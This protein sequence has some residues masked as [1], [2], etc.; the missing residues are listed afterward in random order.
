MIVTH[1]SSVENKINEDDAEETTSPENNPEGTLTQ[2]QGTTI[3]VEQKSWKSTTTMGNV[4]INIDELSEKLKS[5]YPQKT[6]PGAAHE[7]QTPLIKPADAG[8]QPGQMFVQPQ[9]SSISQTPQIQ[10]AQGF[11]YPHFQGQVP[12]TGQAMPQLAQAGIPN[13]LPTTQSASHLQGVVGS[14]GFVQIQQPGH[15]HS[16]STVP[17]DTQV[18]PKSAAQM[19]P[20][21]SAVGQQVPNV[22]GHQAQYPVPS[23]QQNVLQESS[24]GDV[25][26]QTAA[27]SSAPGQNMPQDPSAKTGGLPPAAYNTLGH[28]GYGIHPHVSHLSQ[29]QQMQQMF[30]L[31]HMAP[32]S[33]HQPSYY[34][35]MTPYMQTMMHMSHMMHQ[36]QQHQQQHGQ[37]SLPMHLTFPYS[38]Y[39]GWGYPSTVSLPPQSSHPPESSSVSSGAS[40]PRS[41]TSSRRN[42]LQDMSVQSPYASI[43]N[44]STL[45][46]SMPRSDI[47]TLEQALA[48]TMSRQ[49]HPHPHNPSPVS[50]GTNIQEGATEAKVA[51]QPADV[52]DKLR[53]E[54]DKMLTDRGTLA[55]SSPPC[56]TETKS[57]PDLSAPKVKAIS[58]FKVETVKEDPL[59]QANDTEN[60]ATSP[61]GESSKTN[62]TEEKKIEK[63]GRFQVTKIAVKPADSTSSEGTSADATSSA[64]GIT[65]P[66]I[67][68]LSDTKQDAVDPTTNFQSQGEGA[69]DNTQSAGVSKCVIKINGDP[70]ALNSINANT[71]Y[72]PACNS[73][74]PVCMSNLTKR[75]RS[76]SVDHLYAAEKPGVLESSPSL[77][78]LTHVGGRLSKM[79]K[80]KCLM[81][82]PASCFSGKGMLGECPCCA[83]DGCLKTKPRL[84][85]R[86]TPTWPDHRRASQVS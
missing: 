82:S 70:I 48:K 7:S 1:Q 27:P 15:D 32:Y 51:D 77:S 24:T 25:P 72:F 64:S 38:Q 59:L 35:H 54:D 30:A 65:K 20:G 62:V 50:S 79:C 34:A 21:H 33:F 36:M 67:S 52:P 75:G 6:G 16:M 84:R 55:D 39:S 45:G 58:R 41:P 11:A 14:A 42:I 19:Q 74:L 37:H 85:K 17:M 23:Q 57:E 63:R 80:P 29:M 12:S 60:K 46:R 3:D 83:T 18:S 22:Q 73:S 78:R 56:P 9:S 13:Q 69:S 47:N 81:H 68:E 4:P 40:P 28:M 2:P 53:H 31:M 10:T 44:L 26:F 66:N 61:E 8:L 76:V 71:S 43:E 86:L 49:N 5:I